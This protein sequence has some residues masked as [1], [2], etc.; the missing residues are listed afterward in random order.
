M[1]SKTCSVLLGLVL[2]SCATQ[3]V[4]TAA[5]ACE[6]ASLGESTTLPASTASVRDLGISVWRVTEDNSN[7]VI[8]QGISTEGRIIEDFLF[9]PVLDDDQEVKS[10][11]IMDS[12]RDNYFTIGDTFEIGHT[13]TLAELAGLQAL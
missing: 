10:L 8:V 13:P 3:E 12:L 7:D 5:P 1:T 4:D 11:T 2:F 9:T 6:V